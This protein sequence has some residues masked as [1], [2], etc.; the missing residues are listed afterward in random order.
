[1]E[2]QRFFQVLS[3]AAMVVAF[4]CSGAK[5]APKV[6]PQL[7]AKL[8]DAKA[9]DLFGVVL[10][11]EGE[12][13]TEALV[14]QVMALGVSGG[15]RMNRLPVVAVN[16][17]PAQIVKMTTW[18]NLRSLYLN[19][20][21]QL[22]DHQTNPLVY[23][24]RLRAD[25]DITRRNG[26]LPVT[27]RG[28]TIA[29]DDSGVDATHQD[30]TYNLLNPNAGKTV[31]NVI[32]NMNDKDGLV[33]RSNTLG[34]V[35]AGIIPPTY[36]ENQPNSDTNGGHGTHVASIA[37]GTGHAS[38]GLYAGVAPGANVVGIGSGAVL[39]VV[40]QIAAFDYILTNQTLYN[41][42]VVNNS[43]GNSATGYDADHPVNVASKALHDAGIV[44][45][46][47]NGNDGPDP[48]SQN[49]W[50]PW[51][52]VI[53]AGASTKDGRLASFSSRGVFG[54]DAVHPTVLTPGTGGPAEKGYTSAVI[55]ARSKTNLA[56]NG[57]N[58]DAEIPANFIP[59][60]TQISG[61]SM[62]APHLSGIVANILEAD[63]TL[64]PD[65]VRDVLVRTATPLSTYDEFEVGAGL[66]NVYA[67]VDLAQNP[68]KA[69][70]NFGF[71]G[72]GL[73]LT[74]HDAPAVEG[75]LG[76]AFT[77]ATHE[78]EVPANARFAFV[79]LDWGAQAGEDEVV[80]DSTRLVAN[81]LGLSVTRN[82]QTVASSDDVNVAGL[83]GAREAVKLEFPEA[84]TYAV[85]VSANFGAGT[86]A[87]Q[88][89]TLTVKTYTFD[90]AQVADASALDASLRA[91]IYRLVYDRVMSADGGAFRPDDVLTRAELARA[92]VLGARVPQYIPNRASF[93]DLAAGSP[94]SLYAESLRREGVLG[95]SGAAFGAAAQVNRL[96]AAVA[97]VRALRLDKEARAKAGAAVTSGGTP[98]TDNA[99][100]PA[101]LRGYVQ[102]A[103]DHGL[104]Q[105]FPAEVRQIA[106]G[107]FVAVPGPRFEPARAIKR[108]EFV[109]PLL[110]LVAEM[111]GE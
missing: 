62:A 35:F 16:A 24:D 102:V 109:S 23:A 53:S 82:G 46:F 38:G 110:K 92:L 6:D 2:R 87:D 41:I 31:Q 106:P 70:G 52:W 44:V 90:P 88:S 108:A 99:E 83:F 8:A 22:Y 81:D 79:Q 98:L 101:A 37:A 4:F 45:V 73:S 14:S 71:Y 54:S 85:T 111:F 5:A 74:T 13:V 84:G 66:A 28:I 11:F 59:Y 43:W 75:T 77:S 60:Y 72:K 67:A 103:I 95:V 78:I 63:R 64:T 104:F 51:P 12:R 20:P 58:A 80:L 1:M 27:G 39:F 17:N 65:E 7:R 61:T 26:G 15:Y 32:M 25:A 55:A 68:S 42:R 57:L 105:A 48:N 36:L 76:G 107:Q 40:G 34:N 56:E 94:E 100:I 47:A 69:Y 96:D 91:G 33:V 86:A 19:A 3:A 9:T 97:L 29:I 89:Y 49:R 30:L 10:T 21:V 18:D 50:T 93:T